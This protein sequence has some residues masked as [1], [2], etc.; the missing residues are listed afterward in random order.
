MYYIIH[1]TGDFMELTTSQSF[2]C[3]NTTACAI[4]K[5]DQIAKE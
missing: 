4:K 3:L 2:K 1:V 5:K